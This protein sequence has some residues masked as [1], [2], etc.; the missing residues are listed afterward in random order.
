MSLVIPFLISFALAPAEAGLSRSP[1]PV[2]EGPSES[3]SDIKNRCS[4]IDLKSTLGPVRNQKDLSWCYAFTAAD[5]MS[6]ALRQERSK[7]LGFNKN[8][9][10]RDDVSAVQMAHE[11]QKDNPGQSLLTSR[12]DGGYVNEA[13]QSAFRRSKV[14]AESELDSQNGRSSASLRRLDAAAI[15]AGSNQTIDGARLLAETEVSRSCQRTTDHYSVVSV[16]ENWRATKPG[17]GGAATDRRLRGAINAALEQGRI[18]GVSYRNFLSESAGE[19]GYHASTI[20]GRK[21]IE[22]ECKY[23]IRNSWG[24]DCRGYRSPHREN[25][26]RGEIWVSEKE[27]L[28]NTFTVDYI[29][30][31]A[32]SHDRWTRQADKVRQMQGFTADGTR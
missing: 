17:H 19:H 6:Q 3:A 30:P 28:A 1:S 23:R 8:E 26:N 16:Q 13:L 12:G 4:P 21:V 24:L 10:V 27:L 5:M 31:S 15:A 22:G 7:V 18:P 14:C 32:N 9:T 20:V 11:Y 29:P 2:S 25:C